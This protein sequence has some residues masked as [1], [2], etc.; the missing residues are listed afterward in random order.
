[1]VSELLFLI[2]LDLLSAPFY[3]VL[4]GRPLRIEGSDFLITSRGNKRE[5][6]G[7]MGSRLN[8]SFTLFK[9]LKIVWVKNKVSA[10]PFM[11]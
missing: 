2:L 1:M 4:M 9:G 6:L 5:N 7:I 10:G 8:L 11:R 3:S